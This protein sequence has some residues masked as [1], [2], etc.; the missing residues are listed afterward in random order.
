[1]EEEIKRSCEILLKGGIILYPTDTIWGI[2][3]DATNPEAIKKIYSIKQRVDSKSLLVL[4]DSE[5][6]LNYYIDDVPPIAYDLI[7]LTNKPLTIIYSK[8]RNVAPELIA[9]D[10]TLGIRVTNETFSKELCRRLKK[11]LV[12][13]SAN[14]SGEK[15]PSCFSEIKESIIRS[16]DYVVKYRQEE[17]NSNQASSIIKID[18]DGVFKIIRP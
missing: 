6:K 10:G 11:P 18:T 14:I 4:I 16:V 17:K 1:M 8:A 3:C 2:G 7:E 5:N 15:S 12:S 9:S 13:T